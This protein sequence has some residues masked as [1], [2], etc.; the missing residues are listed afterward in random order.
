MKGRKDRRKKGWIYHYLIKL[1]SENRSREHAFLNI[2][3]FFPPE[4]NQLLNIH[5]ITSLSFSSLAQSKFLKYLQFPI[6]SFTFHLFR[7]FFFC[8]YKFTKIAQSKINN[9]LQVTKWTFP[10]S[11]VTWALGSIC[12]CWWLV[13]PWSSLLT[14]SCSPSYISDQFPI[15]FQCSPSNNML[16]NVDVSQS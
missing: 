5:T 6:Y 14:L 13:P 16:L 8:L 2:F 4:K 11:H 9:D 1:W 3:K 15:S 7:F 12:P 10:S